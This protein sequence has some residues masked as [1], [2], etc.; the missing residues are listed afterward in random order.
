[1]QA[2][3]RKIQINQQ[4]LTEIIVFQYNDDPLKSPY[5]YFYP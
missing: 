4:N 2:T 1:M 5:K 3:K